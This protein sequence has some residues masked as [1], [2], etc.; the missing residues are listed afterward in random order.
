MQNENT[1]AE[2]KG[3][4][5]LEAKS[6]LRGAACSASWQPMT[7]A[8]KHGGTFL[9]FIKSHSMHFYALGNYRWNEKYEI[10]G[11]Q[12]NP[13]VPGGSPTHWMPL[14][15]TPQQNAK[16]L[17]PPLRVSAETENKS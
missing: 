10:G 8:P 17:A 3:S 2:G 5:Q 1:P 16:E 12:F 6:A 11:F 15:H 13:P 14:P 9:V 4:A 7:T